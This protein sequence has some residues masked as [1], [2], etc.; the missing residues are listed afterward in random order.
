MA[1]NSSTWVCIASGPSLAEA[2]IDYCR[3]RGWSLATC[4]LSFRLVP[5]VRCY[6]ATDARFWKKYGDEILSTL[7]DSCEL[8]TGA[9]W[10]ASRWPRVR[11]FK[12][13]GQGAWPTGPGR[14][15]W[16]ALSGFK[17]IH[18]VGVRE[19][20]PERIILLGY[21]HMH[22]GGKAHHH[23]DYTGGWTNAASLENHTHRYEAMAGESTVPI[24][25]ASRESALE[26]FPKVELKNL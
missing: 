8:W 12:D 19:T 17:L 20:P 7:D 23:E 16:G 10:A 9:Q 4:N 13:Q 1:T 2:D 18:L 6:L 14:A 15:C 26:C 22:T 3:S 25:N 5:D 21:D 24:V 11:R